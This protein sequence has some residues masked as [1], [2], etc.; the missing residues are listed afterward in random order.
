[1]FVKLGLAEMLLLA[2]FV[3]DSAPL[4]VFVT[5]TVSVTPVGNV[6]ILGV[7]VF[8]CDTV[9]EWEFVTVEQHVGGDERLDETDLVAAFVFVCVLDIR[10]V[11]DSLALNETVVEEEWDLLCLD[12][13]VYET[14]ALFVFDLLDEPVFVRVEAELA[15]DFGLN[16]GEVV[17]VFAGDE[18][19]VSVSLTDEWVVTVPV[20]SK[21]DVREPATDGLADLVIRSV[22]EPLLVTE[23]EEERLDVFVCVTEPVPLRVMGGVTVNRM[24]P[25]PHVEAVDVLEEELLRV[26]VTE[27]EF[28]F[29]GCTD[30][31]AVFVGLTLVVPD[32]LAVV[33]LELDTL[34]ELVGEAVEV[35]VED[36]DCVPVVDTRPVLVARVVF[37]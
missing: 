34:R 36:T 20:V 4:N 22:K 16:V 31:V 28:V 7:P 18:V 27:A 24:E 11:I 35:F 19:V 6:V 15:E 9:T 30:C 8:A 3:G 25:V 26:C 33:V 32:T 12:D 1:M 2:V 13:G 23:G 29:V 17:N 14:D 5:V 10:P 21:E 37:V